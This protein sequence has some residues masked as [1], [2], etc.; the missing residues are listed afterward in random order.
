MRDRLPRIKAKDLVRVAKRLGFRE[1]RVR[2]S[3]FVFQHADGRR[4]SIPIHSNETIS[5]GLLVK[6][7]NKDFQISQ[8]EL[9]KLL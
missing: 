4:T 9:K 7:I 1:R 5:I 8:E 2:G 3:H 6:I